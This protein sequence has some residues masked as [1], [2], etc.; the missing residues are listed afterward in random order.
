M[1]STRKVHK[2]GTVRA[3]LLKKTKMRIVC[4]LISFS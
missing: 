1:I 4:E 3:N 2:L